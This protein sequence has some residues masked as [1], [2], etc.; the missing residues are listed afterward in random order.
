M[1]VVFERGGQVYSVAKDEMDRIEI[2]ECADITFLDHHANPQVRGVSLVRG[3]Q[4]VLLDPNNA[5]EPIQMAGTLK[6]IL[7]AYQV[8]GERYG[9]VIDSFPKQFEGNPIH[10]NTLSFV[11][12]TQCRT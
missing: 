3:Q 8:S 2:L 4:V 5:H 7:L 6:L 11:E 9:F 12:E 10:I 1:T